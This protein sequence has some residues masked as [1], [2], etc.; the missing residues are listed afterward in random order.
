MLSTWL[1]LPAPA[2]FL[3]PS[4]PMN[5]PLLAAMALA[6]LL[7]TLSA[8]DRP[9]PVHHLVEVHIGDNAT[10]ERLTALN[11]DL[12]GCHAHGKPSEHMQVIATDECMRILGDGGFEFDVVIRNL[13]DHH[14]QDLARFGPFPRT[15]TPPLGQGAMGGHYTLAQMEAILDSFAQNHPG[16][17]TQKVSIGQSIEG[18]DL[19]MV[20]ISDN[21]GVD[22]NE[23]EVLYDA[24]HHAREPLGMEATLLFMDQLLSEYGTDPELTYLV[25]NRELFL[26]PLRQPRRLRIQ[27]PQQPERRRHVA[28]EPARRLRH[29]PQPQLRV[30]LGHELGLVEQQ[31]RLQLP[32]LGAVL[33]TRDRGGRSLRCVTQLRAG[34]LLA[35]LHRRPA[36]ALG[37]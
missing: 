34:V 6:G 4:P 11:L 14:A 28:Q 26:H 35:L 27:P 1:M 29:R 21:V 5:R 32:R 7:P 23:P 33:R 24:L 18:R 3:D 37:V 36:L 19:W 13:E 25:D 30:V 12:V 16:L 8:Q 17:C 31:E 9:E 15:L 20:K 2:P 22:E 10:L